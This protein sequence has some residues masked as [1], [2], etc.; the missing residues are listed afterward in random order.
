MPLDGL[1]LLIVQP[2]EGLLDDVAGAL[3]FADDAHRILQERA[4]VAL[5]SGL[6]PG[7]FAFLFSEHDVSRGFESR[8]R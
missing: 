6:D 8:R 4:F 1:L 5:E 3:D 7:G 2:H